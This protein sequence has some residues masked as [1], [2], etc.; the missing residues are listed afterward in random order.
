MQIGLNL[1]ISC[2]P[3]S[4]YVTQYLFLIPLI[5]V[6]LISIEKYKIQLTLI[7]FTLPDYELNFF[8]FRQIHPLFL[9]FSKKIEENHMK[10]DFNPKPT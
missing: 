10:C 6:I 9:V 7:L 2:I 4:G 8:R 5:S 1:C 3:K